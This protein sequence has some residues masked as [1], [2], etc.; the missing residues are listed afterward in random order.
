MAGPIKLMRSSLPTTV[1][2]SGG[3]GSSGTGL[4]AQTVASIT[5]ATLQPWTGGWIISNQ[6]ETGILTLGPTGSVSLLY[7]VTVDGPARVRLYATAAFRDADLG[8]P[9]QI[10]PT[11]GTQ[12][13]VLVDL[14][15]DGINAALSWNLFP[16]AIL[17]NADGAQVRQVYYTINNL[18]RVNTNAVTTTFVFDP[19]QQ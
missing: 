5:T 14:Y 17:Y 9:N 8:R 10:P 7:K 11:P 2:E 15:L 12:H 1:V 18:D 3:S 6:R 13:G 19:T 4:S 16:V